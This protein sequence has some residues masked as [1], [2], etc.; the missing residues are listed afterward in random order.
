MPDSTQQRAYLDYAATV[1]F[2]ESLVDVLA[3]SSWANANSLHAEGK[4]AAM[5]LRDA[6]S[7]IA[8]ALGAHAPSEIVFTSGGTESDNMAVKG[9]ARV[10]PGAV[11][12]HVVVSAIEHHAVLRAAD[13]L[14]ASGFK[15]DGLAPDPNGSIGPDA[16]E[17]LLARIEDAGDACALVCVQMTNNE[18]GTIQPVQ[19]LAAVAHAHG[20]LFFTDAVQALGKVDINLEGLDV[21][22]AAFSG[23]KIG[24]P[25]GIGA[26]YLRRRTPLATLLHGGGQEAGLRSGTSNVPAACALATAVERAV[27]QREESWEH[28][29]IL[30]ERLLEGVAKLQAPH[31]LRPTLPSDA[32]AVPHIV[33]LV[34]QGLEGETVV[35]RADNAGIALS[36]GSACSS[37]SLEPSHVLTALGLSRDDALG[38]VRVSFGDKT[39]CEDIDALL[40]ALPEVLR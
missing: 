35:L 17:A 27:C 37:A 14:K 23:H 12:T 20:A 30:K 15:V 2:D 34:A 33:S 10:V 24:A 16:L 5:Q 6:R 26:L 11:R 19:K 22:A 3:R 40:D 25:K 32:N 21:D 13:A 28:A 36:S 29:R 39:A 7:R 1:P 9:L 8:R 4:R 38:A 31:A 18:V